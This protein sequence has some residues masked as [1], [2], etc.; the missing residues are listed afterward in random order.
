[1]KKSLR[2]LYARLS[3]T[4]YHYCPVCRNYVKN[5]VPL[6]IFDRALKEDYEKYGFDITLLDSAE[7]LNIDNYGCPV[8]A[9]TD[10]DRLYAIYIKEKI[11]YINK[12]L[13]FIDFA[14]VESLSNFIRSTN[15]FNYRTADLHSENVDDKVDIQ[16]MDIYNGNSI[17]CFLCSHVLEHVKDDKKACHELYRILKPGGWAILMAPIFLSLDK[18]FEDFNKTSEAERIAF[19]G[20]KDHLRMYSKNDYTK[21]LENTGFKLSELSVDYFGK[22]EFKKFGINEKSVLYI[23]E[24]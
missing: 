7:T 24:K 18:T 6:F 16:Q 1:M 11:K 4:F 17:D 13:T 21:M 20:Q 22:S 2:N 19:F 12:R 3:L 8:C 9:A 10:R 5:F 14:P 23:V 15:K